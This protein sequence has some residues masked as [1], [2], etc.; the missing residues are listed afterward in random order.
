VPA[1]AAAAAGG[2]HRQ[3][4]A[5]A[6]GDR[7]VDLGHEVGDQCREQQLGQPRGH[8]NGHRIGSQGPEELPDLVEELAE[9]RLDRAGQ[10][11]ASPE[12]VAD[13]LLQAPE[14]LTHRRP[15]A[16]RFSAD[17]GGEALVQ[18]FEPA[19]GRLSREPGRRARQGER[20]RLPALGDVGGNRLLQGGAH[21]GGERLLHRSHRGVVD[22]RT[23]PSFG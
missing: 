8:R 7:L 21:H 12:E 20:L 9:R 18:E 6:S 4:A 2:W 16:D 22:H 23:L 5:Q 13:A 11:L 19:L 14:Q 17:D 3:R 10:R 1:Q 15:V